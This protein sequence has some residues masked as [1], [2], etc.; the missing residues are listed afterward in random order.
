MTLG[1]VKHRGSRLGS[2]LAPGLEG[3]RDAHMLL[4]KGSLRQG[5]QSM[6][7]QVR[8]SR[9]WDRSCGSQIPVHPGTRG[10][11]E[12]LGTGQCVYM[13]GWDTRV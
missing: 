11:H 9:D 3:S 13:G 2:L 5:P 4:K 12:K 6:F 10:N 7:L 1:E 8:N